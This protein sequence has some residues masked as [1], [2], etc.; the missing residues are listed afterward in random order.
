MSDAYHDAAGQIVRPVMLTHVGDGATALTNRD[1]AVD[2]KVLTDLIK[3][4]NNA[5]G[6]AVATANLLNVLSH[7][8]VFNG[9]S[10]DRLRSDGSANL[11]AT[12]RAGAQFIG[13]PQ[14]N[15]DSLAATLYALAS[16]AA[17]YGFNGTSWDRIRAVTD[18][19]SYTGGIA[20]LLT[21]SCL[22]GK[23]GAAQDPL[24][25]E[26][27]NGDALS[28][29]TRALAVINRNM[30]Y[31]GST[32][33]LERNNANLTLLSSAARNSTISR[34]DQTNHNAKGIIVYFV[35]DATAGDDT[36]DMSIEAKD[37]VTGYYRNLLT[38][39]ATGAVGT[40]AYIVY[41]GVGAAASGV[42]GTA[43]FPL[44]RTWR[45][46]LTYAQ[47]GGVADT[48]TC[49]VGASYIL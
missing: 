1:I 6:V 9:T 18:N 43:S 5:D 40:R 10:W 7:L 20:A 29:T 22:F 39:G 33:D 21:A 11:Y 13:G 41:P 47:V 24:E 42:T 32:W 3:S 48:L 36:F 37:P 26:L 31:N 28:A 45:V 30:R 27:G 4:G 25:I 49:S 17:N 8:M 14:L 23:R 34:A 44:P 12:L 46:T 15:A 38:S 35:I 19:A 16:M 2:L